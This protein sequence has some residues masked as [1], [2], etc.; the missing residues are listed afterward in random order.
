MSDHEHS[1]YAEKHWQ[2]WQMEPFEFPADHPNAPKPTAAEVDAAALLAEITE[3]KELALQQA[4]A[5]GYAAGHQ[6]GLEAGRTEGLK[7]GLEEGYNTGHDKGHDEGYKA[8]YAEGTEKSQAEA[9]RIAQLANG[10]SRAINQLHEDLGQA[11]LALAVN[12]A[13]HVLHTELKDYPE[14]LLPLVRESLKDVEQSDQAVSLLLHP[15]DLPLIEQHMADDLAHHSWRL[16]ADDT[17][18][19]GG[20][21]VKSALGHIDATLETRWRR[22][23]ARLGPSM[24]PAD[25]ADKDDHDHKT[26][27]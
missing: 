2:R 13:Q 18:S 19:A 25:A 23:I 5:E 22:T 8:G 4:K 9:N 11:V 14:Q 3:L 27:P 15:D 21:K 26:T 17:I 10:S 7:S 1:P 16:Q 20:L 24:A 12:I 6:Q